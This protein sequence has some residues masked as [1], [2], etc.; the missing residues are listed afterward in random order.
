MQRGEIR[1]PVTV[2]ILIYVTC[3]IYGI[4]WMLA[5]CEDINKGLGREEFN[6]VKEILLTV[7]TCGLWG[8]WFQWRLCQAVE[9]LQRAWG[10]EP[11][12]EATILFVLHFV[13]VGPMFVQKGL[14]NAWENGTPGGAGGFGGGA[15]PM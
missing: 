4:I 15:P 6:A 8:I 1:N 12:M 7:V 5:I 13:Y 11:E 3:G 14:N 10:V 9:E 2:L